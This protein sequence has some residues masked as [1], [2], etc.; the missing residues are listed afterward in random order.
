MKDPK[1][2]FHGHIEV[3]QGHNHMR[4]HASYNDRILRSG[5]SLVELSVLQG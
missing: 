4:T 5:Q 1:L 3:L 2:S